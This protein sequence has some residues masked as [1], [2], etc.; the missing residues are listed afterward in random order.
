MR[1]AEAAIDDGRATRAL[2][3]LATLTQRIGTRMSV[4]DRIVDD[5]RDE[6]KRR[7]KQVSLKDLESQIEQPRRRRPAVHGGAHAP[8]RVADRRAQAPL[9]V[10]RA[11]SARAW[12]SPTSCGLRARRRRGA[13]HPHRAVP[14][15]RLARRPARGA[16]G[17]V[18]AD[19]AQGLHRPP[20]PALRSRG[21]RRGRDPADRRRARAVRAGELLQEA[22]E[23]DLDALVEVHDERELEAALE[24]EADVLGINNRNLSDFTVDIERTFDLLADIPA[25]KTVVSE[26]GFSTREQLD[27]LERVG[28]DAV[29]IG[30]TLMR[31]PDIEAA[32]ARADGVRR[33]ALSRSRSAASRGSRTPSSPRRSARGRSASS[34]GS[35]PSATWTRAWPPGSRG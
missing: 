34:S 35:R 26:S 22:R 11:R 9:A 14:L 16:H 23:L 7:K 12:R 27:D 25:G 3:A 30:E 13:E 28:V 8:G 6:V 24:V 32:C 1:A 19:P 18:A 4:L 10:A 29:L 31:A 20:L 15:R 17:R 5:T 33:A 2:E 21:G